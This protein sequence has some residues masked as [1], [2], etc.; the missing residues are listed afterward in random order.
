MIIEIIK[1]SIQVLKKL[2]KSGEWKN[3][4]KKTGTDVLNLE[5][6]E[7]E[8]LDQ[9]KILFSEEFLI[10]LA[11]EN[12]K[13]SYLFID[14]IEEELINFFGKKDALSEERK[15]YIDAYMK[16][17]KNK[18]RK[19][20][21]NKY[22][23]VFLHDFREEVVGNQKK[24]MKELDEIK[25][26]IDSLKAIG[27]KYE[28]C[29]ELDK[30][31]R[32]NTKNACSLEL[33]NHENKEFEN[34]LLSKLKQKNVFKIKGKSIKEAVAY[35]SYI[36]L[37]DERFIEYKDKVRIVKDLKSWQEIKETNISGLIILNDFHTR[38][39][40]DVIPNN[41]TIFVY[42]STYTEKDSDI[43]QLEQRFFKNL[44]KKIEA[45]GFDRKESSVLARRS[46]NNYTILMRL[47][48]IGKISEPVWANADYFNIF[49]PALIA[50]RWTDN[51]RVVIELLGNDINSY[52]DYINSLKRINDEQD[53]FWVKFR[54]WYHFD[55]YMISDP[56]AAWDFFSDYI[57]DEVYDII[58]QMTDLF[59]SEID[60]KFDLPLNEHFSARI[61][62]KKPTF[63]D[64]LKR[65]FLETLV[66]LSKDDIK[67]NYKIKR[68]LQKIIK[69]ISTNKD[70]FGISESLPMIME[71]N[72]EALISKYEKEV[73]NPKSGFLN[74]F[75]EKAD[76]SLG[77]VNY[78]TY[79]IWSLEKA[80]FIKDYSF[81]AIMILSK[82]MDYN[83]TYR[84]SNSPLNSLIEALLAWRHENIYSV[85]KKIKYLRYIVENTT[86]GWELLKE[87]L[88]SNNNVSSGLNKPKYI[89]Y[90]LSEK[91][92][93]K[94]EVY[95][96]YLQYYK[97]AFDNINNDVDRLCVF[98]E[99]TMFINFKIYDQLKDITLD[100][101]DS[102]SDQEK[103]VL[104]K[105]IYK[106]ISKHRH[107]KNLDWALQEEE[108]N[109]IESEILN[110]I[111]FTDE[112]YKYQ[113]VFEEYRALSLEPFVYEKDDGNKS[114]NANE[115]FDDELR[116]KAIHKL[117]D[118][119]V[120]WC[121]FIGRFDDNSPQVIGR[122]LG[123][124]ETDL[125]DV[126]NLS[127]CLLAMNRNQ[128]MTSYFRSLYK[129]FGIDFIKGI[130]IDNSLDDKIHE[131]ALGQ[132]ELNS[133]S[134]EF[135]KN[136][137]EKYRKM[138]WSLNHN[139]Y[140]I[141][142]EYKKY[143]LEQYLNYKNTRALIEFSSNYELSTKE[144]IQVLETI[145]RTYD[146]RKQMDSYYISKIFSNIYM[147]SFPRK[148][149]I[150]QIVNL[151][152]FFLNLI[153]QDLQ[154]K[155]LIYKFSKEPDFAAELINYAYKKE[156]DEA[157]AELDEDE[158]I[159][160]E[161]SASLL[162]SVK[163]I[164]AAD[165]NGNIEYE[166]LKNWC[167][168]Y[169]DFIVKQ[170]QRTVGLQYL[171]KFL[172]NS[173]KLSKNEFPQE[174]VKRVFEKNYDDQIS[175]GFSLAISNNIGVRTISNGSFYY[176]LYQKY[177]DYT[178][179]SSMYPHMQKTLRGISKK[180]KREYENEK[181]SAKYSRY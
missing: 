145:Q 168:K 102:A 29:F 25:D 40:L 86:N 141:D 21:P 1:E 103:Y 155:Y 150:N 77:G 94:K 63:S 35:I 169:I 170:D 17:L 67:I 117:K 85:D 54:T 73:K 58:E 172:A 105:A 173:K 109:K 68:N 151:E 7:G 147:D 15:R 30:W 80:L 16:L 51:D 2:K 37:N 6:D 11:K 116:R 125:D 120:D 160:A 28:T 42:N 59:F 143:A 158:I 64:E 27:F 165:I 91:L 46:K 128:I 97:I 98:Y 43:I 138:F 104:Y 157:N 26:K 153:K 177:N 87:L 121:E 88:P 101:L 83:I 74:L 90:E 167:S 142:D 100:I 23:K 3:M 24:L 33:F 127:S 65:G 48:S 131:I 22:E 38:K 114:F 84:K 93:L 174:S 50:N 49:L 166:K 55:R 95:N 71:I 115:K 181:A 159:Y 69:G 14:C 56:E 110:A 18:L 10:K 76:N 175:R 60:P 57:N 82:L 136:I 41:T 70:W 156:S 4:F 108:V 106:L 45:C 53:P 62:G 61:K 13:E 12:K 144:S 72:T 140:Y 36:F 154:P 32:N 134:I 107:F 96:T 39:S 47:I 5:H 130:F 19:R 152:I 78:Y 52:D 149:L 123:E 124:V 162:S 99:N 75:Y 66:L 180:F 9:L 171:G 148:E 8:L 92:K 137:D 163:F 119:G 118:L 44:I 122:Y 129:K 89:Q 164:P 133:E 79:A 34:N 132:M 178:D 112:T 81:R 31:Y 179:Q 126:K 113:Y 161:I 146:K 111:H 176:D 135:L 20:F 139:I